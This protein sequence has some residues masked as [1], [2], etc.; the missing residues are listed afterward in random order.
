MSKFFDALD[1][2]FEEEV[3]KQA[4]ADFFD[5]LVSDWDKDIV[6][7]VTKIRNKIGKNRTNYLVMYLFNELLRD[8][9][10]DVKLCS[11]D[12][13]F[14]TIEEITVDDG[15]LESDGNEMS[16]WAKKYNFNFTIKLE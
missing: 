14:N 7:L 3:K 11:Y 13:Y 8:K 5:L 9:Q 15:F 1:D 16:I 12:D 10:F 2:L 6:H 4:E